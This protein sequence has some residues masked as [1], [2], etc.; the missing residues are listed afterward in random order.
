MGLTVPTDALLDAGTDQLVFV[1]L[2]EGHFEPRQVK[3]GRRT[4]DDDRDL[5]GLKEGE[6]VATGAAFFLDSESQLRAAVQSYQAP[7]A[8][9]AAPP[10]ARDS[11]STSHSARSRIR[12]ERGQHARGHGARCRGQADRGRRRHRDV[13]HGGDA[14]DE[15]AG[16]EE[17]G[18]VAA[19]RRRRVPRHRGRVMM[20]G[21]WDVTVDVSRGRPAPWQ[22]AVR[23]GG[24][25]AQ[26]RERR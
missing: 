4:D 8:A 11:R 13:L 19:R 15:H 25:I 17:P 21:R 7:R 22:Q 23:R 5:E 3:A 26:R 9:G 14:D 6:E 18:N 10:D 20:A 12:R 2:G 24:Q 16:D 1:A